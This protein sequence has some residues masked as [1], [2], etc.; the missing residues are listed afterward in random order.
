MFR[1]FL[2][3]LAC[4]GCGWSAFGSVAVREPVDTLGSPLVRER[5][6]TFAPISRGLGLGDIRVAIDG[7]VRSIVVDV[8]EP[9]GVVRLPLMPDQAS[10]DGRTHFAARIMRGEGSPDRVRVKARIEGM[11]G[12]L[13]EIGPLEFAAWPEPR[14]ETPDWAKGVVW[15]QIFPERFF[16][17][18]PGNDP[19]GPWTFDP[20]W[21]SDWMSVSPEELDAARAR[22]SARTFEHRKTG[23]HHDGPFRDVVFDRRFGGDLQGIVQKLSHVRDLGAGAVY[24]NPIFHAESM[25]KYDATDFRHVDPTFGDPGDRPSLDLPAGE[26]PDPLTWTRTPADRF[27]IDEFLPACRHSGLRVVLDGV[28]NH[29]GMRH[30]AF[31]DVIRRGRDS[32]FA[33]WFMVEFADEQTYPEWKT[34]TLD[35]APGRLATWRAWNG[36]NGGLPSFNRTADRLHPDV[37]AH[38]LDITRRWMDPDGDGDARDGIDGWRLD[39][40]ADV[41]MGFWEFWRTHVKAI[42]P[43]AVLQA[44]IWY[45][46]REYFDGRAFDGQMNYPFTD[47]V[48]PFLARR[49]R[50]SATWTALRLA[51][52]FSHAAQVDLVQMNLLGSH[53]TERLLTRI[54]RLLA[55]PSAEVSSS[56]S[57]TLVTTPPTDLAR[58]L[59]VLGVAMQVAVPGAP[60][61]FAGD[62]LGVWGGNDPD[63]RRPMPWPELGPQ[64]NPALAADERMLAAYRSW[65]TLRRNPDVGPVLRLGDL[66]MP[67][68]GHPDVLVVERRLNTA[69]VIVVVNRG[70]E[71]FDATDLLAEG[72]QAVEVI[73]GSPPERAMVPGVS[74]RV[75]RDRGSGAWQPR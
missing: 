36:R 59:S 66:R 30:W 71:P 12:R 68:S 4:A 19:T 16:N 40:A 55:D 7:P 48:L 53:D 45:D 70:D 22:G 31:E 9:K 24:L 15:Y 73:Q 8:M 62:E 67:P 43:D 10:P 39:V 34:L 6:V 57:P 35:L 56:G 28:W 33:H 58:R 14:M 1:S 61:V 42:N 27:F 50:A 74:A 60:M 72:M 46:A 21:S 20:G 32:A 25:H 37:E 38:I 69:T 11:D 23:T 5:V 44:E 29:V 65:L 64:S 17:G 3:V 52:V 54:D 13:E 26:T 41:P 18:N 51:E 49:S 75:W 63:C 2:T 47:A